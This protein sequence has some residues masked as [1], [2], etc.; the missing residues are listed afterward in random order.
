MHSNESLK[1]LL[2]TMQAWLECARNDEVLAL[3]AIVRDELARRRLRS[4]STPSEGG[5][6]AA[7][8]S[9]PPRRPR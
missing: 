8:H 4:N 7:N 5:E 6:R 1:A 3:H 9:T 2:V